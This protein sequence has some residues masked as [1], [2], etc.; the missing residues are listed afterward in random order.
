MGLAERVEEA[1]AAAKFAVVDTNRTGQV[2]KVTLPGH[3]GKRYMVIVKRTPDG[4]HTDCHIDAGPHGLVECKGNSH[5]TCYHT[6]A[7]VILAAKSVKGEVRFTE[8]PEDAKRLSHLG[9]QIVKV[10]G[11]GHPVWAVFFQQGEPVNKAL[12][13]NPQPV[14]TRKKKSRMYK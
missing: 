8:T 13:P 2:K 14:P 10:V 4:I 3:D 7:A 1:K 6:I 12:N 11:N 9:G 5:A